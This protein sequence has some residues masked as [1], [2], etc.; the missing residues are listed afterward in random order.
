MFADA[1]SLKKIQRSWTFTKHYSLFQIRIRCILPFVPNSIHFC[2]NILHSRQET[3]VGT[4]WREFNMKHLTEPVS[5]LKI[6]K[7]LIKRTIMYRTEQH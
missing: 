5:N 4:R 6:Y 7:F 2:N 1:F 3:P